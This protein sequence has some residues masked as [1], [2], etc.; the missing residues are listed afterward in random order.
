MLPAV[1]HIST[2]AQ[3]FSLQQVIRLLIFPQGRGISVFTADLVKFSRWPCCG[4]PRDRKFE[5]ILEPVFELY[6]FSKVFFRQQG[7]GV[8]ISDAFHANREGSS[9]NVVLI[10]LNKF[11]II[12]RSGLLDELFVQLFLCLVVSVSCLIPVLVPDCSAVFWCEGLVLILKLFEVAQV[13]TYSMLL[14]NLGEDLLI[15][16]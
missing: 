6:H 10:I 11:T 8:A 15:R 9:T 4:W 3:G 13:E 12:E 7:G 1:S 16:I 5:L 14:R 2:L